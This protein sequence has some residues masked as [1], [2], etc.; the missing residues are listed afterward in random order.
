VGAGHGHT[1]HFH[2][3]SLLHR[4][5]AWAKIAALTAFMLIV[6][7]TPRGV[8]PA[9]GAYLVL[10]LL[11]VAISRVPLTF[12]LP[13]MV[14]EVPFVIFAA[15][16]PFVARGPRVDVLGWSLSQ[17]GIDGAGALLAKGT[18]GVLAALLLGATTEVR[19]LL[20]GL[21]K[22]RLPQQLVEILAFMLRYLTV[23]I[24]DLRRMRIAQQARG[25]TVRNIRQW[26]TLASTVG[27]LF[28]RSFERG[29]RVHRAMLARGYSGALPLH[30]GTA[31]ASWRWAMVLPIAAAGVWTAAM[32][33]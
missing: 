33:R 27:T 21:Q 1:L 25:F 2:G 19:D 15:T 20:I 29:E 28:V 32:L 18:L 10:L 3:H 8:W 11:L 26:P 12:L 17:E 13:R 30:D 16:M 7:A 14:V 24:E 31:Q 4:L 9:Y 22:L 6:V 23:I 5:P